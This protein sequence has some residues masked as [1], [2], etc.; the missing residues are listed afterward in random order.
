MTAL[1]R[2]GWFL[3]EFLK[4][5]FSKYW[6]VRTRR[7]FAQAVTYSTLTIIKLQFN[8]FSH[9][10]ITAQILYVYHRLSLSIHLAMSG[11]VYIAIAF[12]EFCWPGN[13]DYRIHPSHNKIL[14]REIAISCYMLH[15]YEISIKEI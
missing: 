6:Q 10:I 3:I 9:I 14:S 15:M 8:V 1:S 11:L 5:Y 12:S 2:Q 13:A 7:V 4:W